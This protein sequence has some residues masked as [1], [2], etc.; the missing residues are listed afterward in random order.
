MLLMKIYDKNYSKRM[1]D[2][3]S[4]GNYNKNLD[5]NNTLGILT[6]QLKYKF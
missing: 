3:N 2:P 5:E 6:G 4:G 1:P